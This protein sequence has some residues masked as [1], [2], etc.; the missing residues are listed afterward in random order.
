[1]QGLGFRLLECEALGCGISSWGFGFSI[2][3]S[4]LKDHL[5]RVENRHVALSIN[6]LDP[7]LPSS[8]VD[9]EIR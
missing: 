8:T 1:M 9:A 7:R 3:V 4:V 2:S 6:T 5:S